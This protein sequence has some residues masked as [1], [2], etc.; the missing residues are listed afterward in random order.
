MRNVITIARKELSIYFTTVIGYA[1]FGSFAFIM[2]LLF[3]TTVNKYQQYTQYYL[4]Q[5][6]PQLLEQLNFNEGIIS[7]MLSTGLWMFLFYV[8]F[9]TMRLFAEEK[10][11]RTFELLLSA[12]ITSFE[13]VLGKFFG[14]GFVVLVLSLIPLAF[15]LIL[16][17][18]G[19]TSGGG[20]PVEWLPVVS[21]TLTMLAVGLCFSSFGLFI[22]S[23]TESQIVAAL[24]TFAVLLLA[25]LLPLIA[26]RVEGDWQQVVEYLT[27][28]SHITRGL[29][30]R[31][32]L[33]DLVYFFSTTLTALFF[34]LR[35][36]ESHRWR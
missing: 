21:G 6:Q 31:V 9:L 33:S 18:Y 27:P 3:V 22:S 20:S 30:G 15:P 10:S 7:P 1:C 8:P 5:S 26:G 28:M 2:G 16:H 34:T 25:F 23:L 36:V 29:Q 4:S 17:L 11:S 35:V 19:T 24:L 13:M 14:V 12:P 32:F